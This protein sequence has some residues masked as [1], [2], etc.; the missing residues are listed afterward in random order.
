MLAMETNQ[1]K[2]FGYDVSP[3]LLAEHMKSG[4]MPVLATPALIAMMEN[5]CMSVAAGGLDAGETTV[6][7]LVEVSHLK[8]S[9]VGAHIEIV[10][11]LTAREGRKLTFRVE[12]RDGGQLIGEGTHVRYVVG[13]ERFLSKL[14]PDA[15]EA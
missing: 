6:G 8:P 14:Y 1:P 4:D 9:A 10:A 7:A 12:A 5:A 11:T 2:S 13:R 15:D 3:E